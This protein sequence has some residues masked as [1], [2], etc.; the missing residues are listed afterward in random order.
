MFKVQNSTSPN[1]N[2]YRTIHTICITIRNSV[3]SSTLH[4]SFLCSQFIFHSVDI[5][6]EALFHLVLLVLLFLI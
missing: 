6:F 3:I 4:L 1:N 2:S 5:C